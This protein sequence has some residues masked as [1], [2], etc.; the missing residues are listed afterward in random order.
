MLVLVLAS[1]VAENLADVL[2]F[3][4]ST[5]EVEDVVEEVGFFGFFVGASLDF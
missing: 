2:L 3:L 5:A 4:K 1:S